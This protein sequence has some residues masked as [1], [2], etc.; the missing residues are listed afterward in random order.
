MIIRKI[1]RNYYIQKKQVTLKTVKEL[2]EKGH[3]ITVYREFQNITAQTLLTI[4]YYHMKNEFT[5]DELLNF[6]FK[7]EI[8]KNDTLISKVLNWLNK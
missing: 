1:K 6:M 5:E 7:Q 2:L 4:M 8:P 3:E